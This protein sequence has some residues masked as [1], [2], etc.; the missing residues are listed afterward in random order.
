MFLMRSEYSLS[1]TWDC[2]RLDEFLPADRAAPQVLWAGP[3]RVQGLVTQISLG[4]AGQSRSVVSSITCWR[5]CTL[6]ESAR[7]ESISAYGKLCCH[8]HKTCNG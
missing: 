3:L 1:L 2:A 5:K 7:K 4:T 8:S 6:L